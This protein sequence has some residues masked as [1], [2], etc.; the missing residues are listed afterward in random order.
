MYFTEE[1]PA[2]TPPLKF[3]KNYDPVSRFLVE[4]IRY[5]DRL[6]PNL[7]V[8]NSKYSVNIASFYFALDLVSKAE[9]TPKLP[10]KTST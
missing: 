2:K 6:K 8:L 4:S 3:Y 1:F 5:L 10:K 7:T 9:C